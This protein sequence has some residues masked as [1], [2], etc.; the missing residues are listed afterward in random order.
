MAYVT[1]KRQAFKSKMCYTDTDFVVLDPNN[2]SWNVVGH[3]FQSEP[4]YTNL[5]I[6]IIRLGPSLT[7]FSSAT[8]E[9]KEQPFLRN[10]KSTVFNSRLVQTIVL[11]ERLLLGLMA[12]LALSHSI[13]LWT[14]PEEMVS[15][16]PST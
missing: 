6:V 8:Q 13:T 10:T 2:G 11:L 15:C 16:L 3:L 9:S 4:S 14:P 7:R 5:M 1:I 12:S